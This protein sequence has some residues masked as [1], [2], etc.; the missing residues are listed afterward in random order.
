MTKH[1]KT[2]WECEHLTSTPPD[3]CIWGDLWIVCRVNVENMVF[4]KNTLWK[5]ISTGVLKDTRNSVVLHAK[6][7]YLT[8]TTPAIVD[9]YRNTPSAVS[10]KG[11]NVSKQWFI[12][13]KSS[14]NFPIN[15][16]MKHSQEVSQSDFHCL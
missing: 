3:N 5:L 12:P 15:S 2:T 14:S 8:G 7:F 6:S 1:T 11:S 16:Y 13:I 4:K 10:G 9:S